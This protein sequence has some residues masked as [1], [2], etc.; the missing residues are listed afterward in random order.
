MKK[1]EMKRKENKKVTNNEK[2]MIVC[3]YDKITINIR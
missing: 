2:F 3:K 1:K